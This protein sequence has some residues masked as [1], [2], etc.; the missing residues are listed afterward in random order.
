[1]GL[2][3]NLQFN[4]YPKIIYLAILF[5]F[6]ILFNQY[7][8]FKGVA[9][10]DSFL[11]FNSGYDLSIGYLPF[12]DYWSVTGP[13]LDLIQAIYFKAFGIS[14]FSYVLHAST[15]NLLITLATFYTLEKFGLNLIYCFFYAICTATL[16]YPIIGTPFM[17]H[18]SAILSLIA[19]FIFIISL[20]TKSNF[21]W[22]FIPIILGLAFLSKQTPAAFMGIIIA[23]ISTIY[24]VYNFDRQK[25]LYFLAGS[26]A[27]LIFF[28]FLL[29]AYKISIVSFLHQYIF[30][31]SS[32]GNYR[33][34]DFLFPLEFKRI[35]LRFKLIHFSQLILII[36]LIRNIYQNFNYIKN[37]E[38]L[39]L[40]TIILT[41]Y[42]FIF[43]QLLTLNQ[44]YVF[45]IIP[46]LLGFSQIYFEK[47]FIN[48]KY[49]FL[50]FIIFGMISTLYYNYSYINNRKFLELSNVNFDKSI[51]GK[52]LDKK[53][54]NLKWITHLYPNEPK[55]EILQLK[56]IINIL[57]NDNRIKMV[58]TDYQF[59][60]V[61]L[62]LY[63]Y[64]P[65]KFWHVGVGYPPGKDAPKG[66][67]YSGNKYFK[68]YKKFFIKKLKEGEIEFVYTIKPLFG[69]RDVLKEIISKNCYSREIVTDIAY[70][71]TIIPCE[72]LNN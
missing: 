28:I 54:K 33:M 22:F 3:T 41:S 53:L 34:Y 51:N 68:N 40:L 2:V 50:F 20:K 60:S 1:M 23:F 5:F 48:K 64:S 32:V 26:F 47:H 19:I 29:F 38:F 65:N 72:D 17:D 13:L 16:A 35:F 6:S 11:I 10:I 59:I 24:F 63:D 46:F 21:S 31:P 45:F 62:S 61:I 30:F 42:A 36:V 18:H 44:K 9:P 70:A 27:F 69:D 58:V 39:I 66:T 12:R 57:K 52:I 4:K 56:K 43:Q 7:Y 14:W 8:G 15:F 71:E 25:I 49:T 55:E 67:T 37:N